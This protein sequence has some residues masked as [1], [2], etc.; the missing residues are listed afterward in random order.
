VDVFIHSGVVGD[1]VVVGLLTVGLLEPS[2][3]CIFFISLR[4]IL[5]IFF[6]FVMGGGN[7]KR[8]HI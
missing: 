7:I 8:L 4:F 3:S 6:M 2:K 5:F 1:D